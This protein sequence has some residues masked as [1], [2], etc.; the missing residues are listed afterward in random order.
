MNFYAG[1]DASHSTGGV[2]EST[3][4]SDGGQQGAGAGSQQ[5]VTLAPG[6]LF[7]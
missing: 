1:N 3:G 5:R 4:E 2:I 7:L 6:T